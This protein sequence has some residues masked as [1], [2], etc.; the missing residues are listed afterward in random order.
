MPPGV[1]SPNCP[2]CSQQC[3]YIDLARP[4]EETCCCSLC[5]L[6]FYSHCWPSIHKKV[7]RPFWITSSHGASPNQ[8]W[9]LV[10]SLFLPAISRL[11]GILVSEYVSITLA[12]FKVD[13]CW[14]R[15]Q[16]Q[17]VFVANLPSRTDKLDAFRVSA[18][19]TDFDFEVI[20]GVNGDLMSPKAYPGVSQPRPITLASSRYRID[21]IIEVWQEFY[22]WMLASAH[23][24]RSYVSMIR[25]VL[26]R[27]KKLR[28]LTCFRNPQ[29]S[30]GPPLDCSYLR[31]WYRLGC[32]VQVPIGALCPG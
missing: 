32:G 25:L 21:P 14:Y 23:G 19:L 27:V 15:H 11:S 31:G 5:S 29:R 30:Q 6:S 3:P 22:P 16:F 10:L 18:S 17:K 20:E 24:L 13:W 2:V 9:I 26:S 7:S 28:I 8:S 12:S 4:G 1:Q